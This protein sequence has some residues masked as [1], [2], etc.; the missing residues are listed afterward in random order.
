MALCLA[1]PLGCFDNCACFAYAF[2]TRGPR[3]EAESKAEAKVS[4]KAYDLKLWILS[5]SIPERGGGGRAAGEGVELVR[6]IGD[7]YD[8]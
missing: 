6:E 8:N 7:N 1:W 2:Q 3:P 5:L 4:K